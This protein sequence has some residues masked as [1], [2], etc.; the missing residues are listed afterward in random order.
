MC[1]TFLTQA[2]HHLHHFEEPSPINNEK[3]QQPA[4]REQSSIG[5]HKKTLRVQRVKGNDSTGKERKGKEGRKEG[6][7]RGS[8]GQEEKV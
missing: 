7:K 4:S 1:L 5:L 2:S 6:E 8:K 3:T